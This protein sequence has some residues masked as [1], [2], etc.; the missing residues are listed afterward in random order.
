M[1]V[2][3]LE[4]EHVGVTSMSDA[5][6][7]S[8]LPFSL[9][10]PGRQRNLDLCDVLPRPAGFE[11]A[12]IMSEFT[13]G[14]A[15]GDTLDELLALVGGDR[16][17]PTLERIR[18]GQTKLEHTL[19]EDGKWLSEPF[20]AALRGVSSGNPDVLIRNWLSVNETNCW[21]TS[22]TSYF[23]FDDLIHELPVTIGAYEIVE[24]DANWFLWLRDD[25]PM[26]FLSAPQSLIADVCAADPKRAMSVPS[27]FR[28]C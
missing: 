19:F 3:P 18:L 16:T 6:Y 7:L 9:P 5:E 27:T 26:M 13:I 23:G 12:L 14:D 22:L 25:D 20:K 11:F 2:D 10:K 1:M 8:R 15:E 4:Q 28:Y 24:A 21:Y 17:A